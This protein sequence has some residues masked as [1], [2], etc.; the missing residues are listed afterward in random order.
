[1]GWAEFFTGRVV[2]N[3]QDFRLVLKILKKHPAAKKSLVKR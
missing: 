2:L 1:M 3:T